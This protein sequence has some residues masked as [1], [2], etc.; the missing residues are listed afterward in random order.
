MFLMEYA[1]D[2]DGLYQERHN[3]RATPSRATQDP[4]AGHLIIFVVIF[5]IT[6]AWGLMEHRGM[7]TAI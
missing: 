6:L 2:Q 7:A 4:E 1:H 5:G 3:L